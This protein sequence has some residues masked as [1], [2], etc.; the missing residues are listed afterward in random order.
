L[1]RARRKFKQVAER[2]GAPGLYDEA[3]TIA[4]S[5]T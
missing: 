3:K 1:V 2:L 4:S 5:R